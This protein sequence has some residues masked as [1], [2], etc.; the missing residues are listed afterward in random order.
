M[1]ESL[2]YQTQKM[3]IVALWEMY[4]SVSVSSKVKKSRYHHFYHSFKNLSPN[5]L[6]VHFF[7]LEYYIDTLTSTSTTHCSTDAA[8]L[9]GNV[10]DDFRQFYG[11]KVNIF[12]LMKLPLCHCFKNLFP[13]FVEQQF[14]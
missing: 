6:E 11:L 4:G 2:H 3:L 9:M 12:Q 10:G 7:L 1:T 8:I 13:N 5:S 14:Y